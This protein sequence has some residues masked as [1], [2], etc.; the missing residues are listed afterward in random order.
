[1][2]RSSP[3]PDF[4]QVST[5]GDEPFFVEIEENPSPR[6]ASAPDNGPPGWFQGPAKQQKTQSKPPAKPSR[7]QAAVNRQRKPLR[8]K[9]P[10]VRAE[11]EPEEELTWQEQVKE[12]IYGEGGAGYGIS[13]VVHLILLLAM[14]LWILSRPSDR[15]LITEV[16]QT[17]VVD[18][19]SIKDVDIDVDLK[20][21]IPEQINKPEFE[22]APMSLPDIGVN[23]LATS[24][25]NTTG[26]GIDSIIPKQAVTKGSFTVWTEPED[27]MPGQQYNIVIQVKLKSNV[28][29][30]RRSDIKGS[31][32][33]TDGYKDYFGGPTEPGYY[34]VKDNMVR[35]QVL[36][37]GAAQL[38]KDVIN[39]E[40]EL[41]KE[42]Q[43]IE[44]VF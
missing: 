15:D 13:V 22:P 35:F 6:E 4:S 30:L 24:L 2:G 11:D 31:V 21:D 19:A 43:Q 27:P 28:A 36:V 42:K 34:T 12:W 17:E 16:E 8:Q 3:P 25:G 26:G 9:A 20:T 18:V 23:S 29:K 41:L 40:S 37:P 1:M 33:G 38:V 10:I 7:Q 39:V 32:I 5:A 14:S 44:I